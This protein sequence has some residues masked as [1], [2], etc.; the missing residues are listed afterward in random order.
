MVFWFGCGRR[1]DSTSST[2]EEEK[3]EK[4]LLVNG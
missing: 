1:A 4:D 3:A 2:T